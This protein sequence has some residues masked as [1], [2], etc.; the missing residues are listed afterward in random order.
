MRYVQKTAVVM[1]LFFSSL[2]TFA[3]RSDDMNSQI[4][5]EIWIMFD[6]GETIVTSNH[7]HDPT[8]KFHYL[9]GAQNYINELHAKG[10]KTGLIVNI[11]ERWGNTAEIK[12][13]MLKKFIIENW[14]DS[15]PFD[16]TPFEDLVVI[17]MFDRERKPAPDLFLKAI[18]LA[19]S[20]NAV[21]LYQGEDEAE[22][23]ASKSLGIP[24]FQVGVEPGFYLESTKIED[25]INN[26]SKQK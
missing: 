14:D 3:D 15:I 18:D 24:S 6:L 16:W 4:K 12:M 20:K 19:R 10:Y 5:Q 7:S 17:P 8:A 9:A 1:L 21:F 22:I 11:P 2:T 25:F 13:Q 26:N 23:K